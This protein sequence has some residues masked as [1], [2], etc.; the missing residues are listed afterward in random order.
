[1]SNK[2]YEVTAKEILAGIGGKENVSGAAHCATRLRIVLA[3]N[4]KVD[5]KKLE[6]LE[7]VKGVF[8]AGDQLQ[9][10]IGVGKV[11]EV[12]QMLALQAGLEGMDLSEVK[13]ASA[14]KQNKFQQAIKALSDVFVPIIPGLLAAALLMGITGLLSQK[15]VFGDQS[16]VEMYPAI[17]GLNRFLTIMS[18]GIFVFLPLFV[19]YSATKRFGGNPILGLVIGAIMLHPD[20]S[21]AYAV[22]SG[23]VEPEVINIF[24]LNVELVGFQGGII[25]ALMMGYVVAKAE[26]LFNKLIP[27][28]VRL[29]FVPFLT[30]LV[31][32]FLLFTIIGPVGRILS[33]GVTDGLMWTVANL[34]IFGYMIFAGIQQI[35]VI[36]GLH[37]VLNAVEAQLIADTGY[38]FLNPLMSVA[39]MAQGGAVLGFLYLRWNDPKAKQIGTSAFGSILFGISEPALFGVNLR[40]KFPLIAGCIGGALGGAYIYLFDVKSLG[41]GTTALPGLAVI[42]TEGGGHLHYIIACLIATISAMLLTILYAKAKKPSFE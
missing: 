11:N 19:V 33:N 39:L 9:L 34:G 29:I 41:F 28:M 15:G 25:I 17:E 6:E 38:T 1:M 21:N 40:H 24:G 12:Y 26:K 22:G 36:T 13:A 20:L 31:S 42:S 7:M 2:L 5:M 32:G 35:I 14:K 4:D 30:V 16:I 8:I 27:D 37:H 18:N 23:S 3:D 10:I